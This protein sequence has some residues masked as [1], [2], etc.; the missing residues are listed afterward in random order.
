MLLTRFGFSV[1]LM[2]GTAIILL[3]LI[4]FGTIHI[5]TGKF[6]SWQWLMIITGIITLIVSVLFWYVTEI[7]QPPNEVRADTN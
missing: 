7:L 1:V 6:M 4:A 2:N 3:G 5:E